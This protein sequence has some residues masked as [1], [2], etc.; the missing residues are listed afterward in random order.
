MTLPRRLRLRA[1]VLL[2]L[3]ARFLPRNRRKGWISLSVTS[4]PVST[5]SGRCRCRTVE[6]HR[7]LGML[8]FSGTPTH[9][10][11]LLV[12]LEWLCCR[13]QLLFVI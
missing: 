4:H 13:V 10:Q 3:P 6:R 1:G 2:L 9:W 7:Q 12:P 5:L 11:Q 8:Q